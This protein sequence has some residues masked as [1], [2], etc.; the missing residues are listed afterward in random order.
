[1]T[2]DLH[3][4]HEALDKLGRVTPEGGIDAASPAELR[5]ISDALDEHEAVVAEMSAQL[6]K[7]HA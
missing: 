5:A 4:L 6:P 7:R 1:M 2:L 3:C